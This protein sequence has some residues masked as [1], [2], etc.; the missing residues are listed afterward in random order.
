[1]LYTRPASK[2]RKD[3]PRAAHSHCFYAGVY[4]ISA[5][6]FIY[7]TGLNFI[8]ISGSGASAGMHSTSAAVSVSFTGL[9]AA[10]DTVVVYVT[11]SVDNTMYWNRDTAVTVT[12]A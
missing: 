2:D 10:G 5:T 8:G 9:F 12:L 7:R 4:T 6:A 1:M 11:S 3:R